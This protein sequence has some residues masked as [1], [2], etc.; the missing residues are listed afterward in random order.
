MVLVMQLL[1]VPTS[2]L[3]LWMA[4]R[5]LNPYL[6]FHDGVNDAVSGTVQAIGVF[7]GMTVGLIAVAVW[8]TSS[9][10][11][12]LVHREASAIGCVNRE[13]RSFPDPI[14]LNFASG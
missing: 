2:S 5:Y 7:Y 1:I 4:R 8:N 12:D 3:G 6:G 13:V 11:A 10:G 9:A 14:A